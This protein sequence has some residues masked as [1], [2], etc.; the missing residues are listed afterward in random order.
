LR[1]ENLEAFC[2]AEL[3]HTMQTNDVKVV[4]FSGLGLRLLDILHE[5]AV[6]FSQN[7]ARR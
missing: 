5:V 6:S 3:S 4:G 2:K 1:A 7:H